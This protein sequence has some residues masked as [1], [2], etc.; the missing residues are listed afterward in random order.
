MN[1]PT[2]QAI[3]RY[4]AFHGKTPSRFR[5]VNKKMPTILVEIARPEFIT[6]FSDKLNGGG[7]G[8]L[9]AFKHKFHKS[10]KLYSSP[11]GKM[12]VIMGPKLNVTNRG[13]V[14]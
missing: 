12:L 1:K 7:D 11:D 13:I 10:T 3:K 8:K 2:P 9:N 5:P 6:Y 4:K 14:G